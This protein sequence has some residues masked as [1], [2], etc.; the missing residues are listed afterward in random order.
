MG[1]SWILRCISSAIALTYSLLRNGHCAFFL[2][3]VIVLRL[4]IFQCVLHITHMGAVF[5]T[6]FY[7]AFQ[8]F[9]CVALRI[10]VT[11]APYAI[12]FPYMVSPVD[13]PVFCF[14][15]FVFAYYLDFLN[16]CFLRFVGF[17]PLRG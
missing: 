8:F 9:Q 7:V 4:C 13:V 1:T 2:D 5:S 14:L 11:D 17:C 6:V 16:F 15:C 12:E 10:C 3:S